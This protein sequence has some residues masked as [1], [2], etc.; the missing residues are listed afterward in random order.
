MVKHEHVNHVN[1]RLNISICRGE[2][3]L[4]VLSKAQILRCV[5]AQLLNKIIIKVSFARC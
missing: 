5:F 1:K 3:L 2:K 4:D